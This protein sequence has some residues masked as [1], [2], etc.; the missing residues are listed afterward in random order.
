MPTGLKKPLE[1]YLRETT[2]EHEGWTIINEALAYEVC[3]DALRLHVPSL[4]RDRSDRQI[5]DLFKAG[6]HKLANDMKRTPELSHIGT[7]EGYSPLV[8]RYQRIIRRDMG[9]QVTDLHETNKA[10]LAQ[11][12]RETFLRLYGYPM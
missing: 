10:G 12:D 7:I 9:F 5:L 2:A 1:K 8:Y 6:L 4:I 11:I 3:G